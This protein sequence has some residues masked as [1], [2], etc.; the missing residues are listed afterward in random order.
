M[1]LVPDAENPD[2]QRPISRLD[3]EASKMGKIITVI[4]GIF[5]LSMHAISIIS[6]VNNYA[7]AST[8]FDTTTWLL[9]L[10]GIEGKS[11][12]VC[13]Q[14][15]MAKWSFIGV[16]VC[17]IILSGNALY[18]I[19]QFFDILTNPRYKIY[20]FG[21]I[22]QLGWAIAVEFFVKKCVNQ[23]SDFIG[24]SFTFTST[25]VFSTWYAF[26]PTVAVL[27]TTATRKRNN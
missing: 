23:A 27:Y 2:L 21:V 18:D 20:V 25:W 16:I 13:D 15:T 5:C 8:Q 7:W 24:Q 11:N 9:N 22:V 19:Y 10:N 12:F 14:C 6:I 3:Y 1:L 17:N 26:M 4:L